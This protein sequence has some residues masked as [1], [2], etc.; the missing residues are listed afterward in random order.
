MKKQTSRPRILRWALFLAVG[1][2][3]FSQTMFVSCQPIPLGVQWGNPT[4]LCADGSS[5]GGTT[6]RSSAGALM[7]V[8]ITVGTQVN[9]IARNLSLDLRFISQLAYSSDSARAMPESN[10][11]IIDKI[12]YYITYPS[13]FSLPQDPSLFP[14]SSPREQSIFMR[15]NPKVQ[16]NTSGGAQGAII[17]SD[18]NTGDALAMEFIPLSLSQALINAQELNSGSQRFD[19]ILNIKATGTTGWG[20]KIETNYLRYPITVCKGC[21]KCA[22]GNISEAGPCAGLNGGCKASTGN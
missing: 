21:T 2:G 1:L 10:F 7:D 13:N 8:E 16:V 20:S 12:T 15:I 3:V 6:A 4:L 19:I 22:V 14:E 18:S 17:N 11:V 9:T 5:P